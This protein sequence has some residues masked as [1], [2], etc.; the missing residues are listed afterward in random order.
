MS[1]V[2]DLILVHGLME[3]RNLDFTEFHKVIN[4]FFDQP[5]HLA[6]DLVRMDQQNIGGNKA[7]QSVVLMG[8]YNYLDMDAF[9]AYL[10]TLAWKQPEAAQLFVKGEWDECYKLIRI[11]EDAQC[12]NLSDQEL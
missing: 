12:W 10:R 5:E 3:S 6:N 2:T 11:V 7:F 9:L 4:A 1:V 8:A